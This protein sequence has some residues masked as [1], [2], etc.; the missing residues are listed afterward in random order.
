MWCTYSEMAILKWSVMFTV[1]GFSLATFV[2]THCITLSGI[3]G[4]YYATLARFIRIFFTCIVT[5]S[6]SLHS[7]YY[8]INKK[9]YW[10]FINWKAKL[11][12]AHTFF[13]V[14]EKVL[15]GG[16]WTISRCQYLQL[17]WKAIRWSFLQLYRKA[18]FPVILNIWGSH[19]A[20]FGCLFLQLHWKAELLLAHVSFPVSENVL[21]NHWATLRCLPAQLHWKAMLFPVHASFFCYRKSIR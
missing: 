4:W 19:W 10:S 16:Y 18:S 20:I 17:N 8:Y 5:N 21:G 1:T 6:R 15:C 14:S 11:F 3:S 9:K 2:A 13:L 7:F 12:L